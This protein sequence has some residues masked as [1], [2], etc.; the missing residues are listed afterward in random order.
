MFFNF[1]YILSD[2]CSVPIISYQLNT[3][4]IIKNIFFIINFQ[5]HAIELALYSVFCQ[6]NYR[7]VFV[8]TKYNSDKYRKIYMYFSL[9]TYLFS[10][11]Y[12]RETLTI[13][14]IFSIKYFIFL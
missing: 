11:D 5:Y 3:Q 12:Y 2:R 7:M 14:L 4:N 1:F 10:I 9:D 8:S 13:A 6:H